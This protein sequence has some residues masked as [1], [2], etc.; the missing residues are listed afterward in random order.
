MNNDQT[1]HLLETDLC[2][3]MS[4]EIYALRELLANL[5]AEQHSLLAQDNISM[6]QI[7]KDRSL[8][9]DHMQ[10]WREKIIADI[11]AL[12][13]MMKIDFKDTAEISITEWL[14][15]II[16][17][18]GHEHC[19]ILTLRDQILSLVDRIERQNSRIHYLLDLKA[20]NTNSSSPQMLPK[21]MPQK[22]KQKLSIL[23]PEN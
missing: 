9:I 1:L 23:D 6:Q 14:S 13:M 22:P 4:K 20:S 7:L 2:N 11:K 21:S 8:L 15:M 18:V 5:Q 3:A 17:I 19:E 16:D 12:G 10:E